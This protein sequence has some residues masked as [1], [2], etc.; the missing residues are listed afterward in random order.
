MELRI[1]NLAGL[2]V[3]AVIFGACEKDIDV[4]LPDAPEQFVVEGTIEPGLP[5]FVILTRTQGW[6]EPLSPTSLAGI[7]VGGATVTVDNGDGPIALDQVCTGSLTPE[8]LVLVS[9][10]TGLDPALL[11]AVDLCVYA[12]ANTALFGEAGRT[13]TLRVQVEGHELSASTTIPHP[14]PLDSVW[15]KLAQVRPDDDSLGFAWCRLTDPDTTGNN[16]RW[17]ARRI[18]HRSDGSAE[19]PFYISPFGTTFD[20]RFINGLSVDLNTVRGRAPFSNKPEDENEEAGFFK[21]GDTIAVKFLSIGRS[22]YEFYK[23]YEENVSSSGD[24][25][26]TPVNARGNSHGG[27]GIWAGLGVYADTIYCE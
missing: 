8:Q 24:I 23:S 2:A 21:T 14:V 1:L 7:F 20:D 26:S 25:F 5:P 9:E 6:F 17:M 19:D 4:D 3:C 27:L 12:S 18:S 15:F 13:Y 11:H 16:Y 10:L 22:E